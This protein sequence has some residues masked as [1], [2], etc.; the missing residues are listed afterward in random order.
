MDGLALSCEA[1][2]DETDDLEFEPNRAERRHQAH[3]E[4]RRLLDYQALRD[5]GIPYSPSHL[6]R[7]GKAGKFPLPIQIAK[8]NFW[9]EAEVD[10][11]VDAAIAA[12]NAR[13]T[14]A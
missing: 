3:L 5:K 4:R 1:A 2:M 12:R 11:C 10:A 14:A 7:L 9:I 13:A 8:K 6:W